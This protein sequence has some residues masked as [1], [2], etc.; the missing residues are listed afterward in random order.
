MTWNTT[1]FH[2]TLESI[3]FS[4][5]NSRIIN[6]KLYNLLKTHVKI[7]QLFKNQ[8][9]WLRHFKHKSELHTQLLPKPR[10][11][12][13]LIL[14]T[15]FHESSRLILHLYT[16]LFILNHI[17]NPV[18]LCS[19]IFCDFVLVYQ[20]FWLFFKKKVHYKHLRGFCNFVF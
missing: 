7:L 16:I 12:S 8:R 19:L 14:F 13:F 3:C 9:C 6:R 1:V 4:T 10:C 17:R 5:L 18:N 11:C 20:V 2:S 15:C